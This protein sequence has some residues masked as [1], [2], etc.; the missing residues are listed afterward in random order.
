MTFR[1]EPHA[2]GEVFTVD[3]IDGEGRATTSSMIL[4]LD[5]KPRHFQD[6]TC[7]G[8]QSSRRLDNATVEIL[9]ECT[10]GEWTRIVRRLSANRL[11]LETTQQ[12]R[13]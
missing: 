8:T 12:Q 7:S 10:S 1:F 4:Y 13:N 5:N 2:K 6:P 11:V 3:R 9:L